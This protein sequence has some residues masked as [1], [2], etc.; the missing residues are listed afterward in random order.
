MIKFEGKEYPSTMISL[1]FGE[2]RISNV[3]LNE[4]L[5]NSDGSYVSEDARRIDERIFYFV[6]D[7]V[8]Q[9]PENE[10]LNIILSEI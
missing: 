8:L 10:L 6:D 9:L 4:S 2:R 1:P 7:E 3:R 5:M